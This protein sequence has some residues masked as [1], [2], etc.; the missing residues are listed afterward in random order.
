MV[1]PRL[2]SAAAFLLIGLVFCTFALRVWN[3]HPVNRVFLLGPFV[4]EAG[5]LF[6]LRNLKTVFF[7]G[8]FSIAEACAKVAY[9]YRWSGHPFGGAADKFGSVA[10][11]FALVAACCV[12]VAARRLCQKG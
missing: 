3:T 6:I 10:A 8:L 7:L 12:C 9:A 5:Q 1:D 11:V 2:I 4:T